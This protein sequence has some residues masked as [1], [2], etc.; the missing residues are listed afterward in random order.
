MFWYCCSSHVCSPRSLVLAPVTVGRVH[1]GTEGAV[2]VCNMGCNIHRA[3]PLLPRG[4]LLVLLSLSCLPRFINSPKDQTGVSGGVASFVCQATGEPTPRISW[5]KKGKK[6][7]SQ[8][9]EVIEFEDGSGSVLRIQP[10]RESRDEAF[11]EC[12]ASNSVGE[13]STSARLRV[14]QGEMGPLFFFLP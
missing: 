5:M 11:Y 8:R 14:L 3:G 6:I 10:L 13:V 9:F 12:T 4:G 1:R 7:S 2:P